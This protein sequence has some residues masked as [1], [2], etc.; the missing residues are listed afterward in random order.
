MN[1]KRRT[2]LVAIFASGRRLNQKWSSILSC[3]YNV[4]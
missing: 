1:G 4:A 2:G 3:P